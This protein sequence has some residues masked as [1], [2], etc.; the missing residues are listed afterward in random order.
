MPF[1]LTLTV[2][3]RSDTEWRWVLS[4][5]DGRFLG[6]HDV[7]LDPA[8]PV[9]KSFEDLPRQ[10]RF[11]EDVRS[12]EDV[13]AELGAWMG[14]K[15]FGKVGEKLI[16]YEQSPACVVQVRVPPAAQALLFRPFELAHL[17]GKPMSERG[18]R[19]I[20][21]VARDSDHRPGRAV[22][23]DTGVGESLRVLAIFSLPHDLTP[24]NLRQEHR[25]LQ[26][27][28][29][30]FVHTRGQSIELRLL[31]Y[32]ATRQLLKE[33]LEEAPGW[34]VIH[35]S[36]HGQEGEL[37]LE[38]PDGSMDQ[39]AAEDLTDLLRPARARLKLLTLSAC[40]SG[41]ADIRAARAQIGLPNPPMRE[42]AVAPSVDALPS[43]GQRLAEELDSAVLAMRFPVLDEFA[44]EL[45]LGLYERMLERR[46]PLPQALQL[47]LD[48]ALD[49]KRDPHLPGFSRMTPLLFGERA[50]DLRLQAPPCPPSFEPPA[51]GLFHFPSAPERFVGRLMPMLRARQVIAT[52]SG[53]TGVLFYGMAGAGK[54]ACALEL[55]YGYD[56]QNVERFAAFVW[57]E[58]PKENHDMA[59]ALTRLALSMETQLPGLELV[60]LM[61]EPREFETK[62]LPYLRWLMANNAI[63]L[64][65]DNLE[66]LL[67]TQG[68]WRDQRWDVLLKT[69]LEHTGP[70]RLVLTSRR[71]PVSLA[72]HPRLQSDSIHALS[73][74]ESV[75][76]ARELP[77]LKEMFKDRSQYGKLQRILR[78]AQG[79][80]KLLELADGLVDDP[81]AL[82]TSLARAESGG[83]AAQVA[84]LSFF[85]SGE[86]GR[87]E[88]DFVQELRRW[89]EGVAENLSPTARLLVQFLARMEDAD[90]TD[91]VVQANWQ[92]FLKRLIGERG[93]PEQA[94]AEP[95]LTQARAALTEGV[96][97]LEAALNQ[98][99]HS[100]LIE[101]ETTTTIGKARISKESLQTLLPILAADI[102]DVTVML[103]NPEGVNFAELLP[104]LQAALATPT[105]GV[106]TWLD[107]QRATINRR[108]FRLHPGVGEALL[109]SAFS[110]VKNAVDTELGNYFGGMYQYGVRTEMEGGGRLVVEGA[111]CAAPY[112]LRAERWKEASTLLERMLHRDA[113]PE[114]LALAIPL[115]RHIAEKTRGT[116]RELIDLGVLAFA[117]SKADRHTE[118]EQMERNR[119]ARFVAQG[120]YR[121]AL[122]AS[123]NL[124]NLLRRTGRFEESLMTAEAN[125]EYTRRGG[126]GPWSQSVTEVQRLQ[127]LNTLGR[128]DEVTGRSGATLGSNERP[129][130]RGW[131]PGR[132]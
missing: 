43:L 105:E 82:D 113:S 48:D 85:E 81:T 29:R 69:L 7:A 68:E 65:L 61:D 124:F 21:T 27:L 8:D 90:R 58:A 59:D 125:A 89:T 79:H 128:Y 122:N 19:L 95:V 44:T 9:Y 91:N 109:L 103:G 126:L 111:R 123:S 23:K 80:P 18:F 66:G 56:P 83:S 127:A 15:V 62:A 96:P 30:D 107:D 26:K 132:Y 118:A 70:S 67:T 34:D 49:P 52:E 97:G 131:Q 36:G 71:L 101:V 106:Q 20:Y 11:F 53:K 39:I 16:A 76:L 72:G 130:R 116:E 5:R 74:P 104:H 84:A 55:A 25:R 38:E 100:G 40:Y 60:G 94:A 46:Q 3:Y 2:D 4:D 114:T 35:F 54:T 75:L 129:A 119:I 1:Q 32:G 92:D 98:L 47:A 6:D 115:L 33:V 37:I 108:Q 42:T 51:T 88:D 64:V 117:L 31:Q 93:D 45:T 102:P 121:L 87:G 10:L 120:N 73:F 17:D 28:V 86:S 77:H 63:L 112:L 78:A 12:A 110:T 22:P 14:T 50:A 13:L 41:A 24:L 57:H 99:S